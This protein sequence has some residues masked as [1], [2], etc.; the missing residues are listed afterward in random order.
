MSEKRKVPQQQKTRLH[1]RSRHRERYNF[2]TLIA[3]NPELEAYVKPNAYNDESIDYFNPDAV[4]A[5]NKALLKHHYGIDFWDIPEGYLCPP[6]PGRAD[7]LH[8]MADLLGFSN[9]GLIPVGREIVVLDIGVG[10]NCVYPLL[11]HKDYGWSFIGSE[12]DEIAVESAKKIVEFNQLK[13]RIGIRL[14]SDK[15]KIFEG[16]LLRGELFDLSICNPPFHASAEDARRG[17]LRKL[18]NLKQKTVTKPS[19][20][21]GGTNNE[22]W[23][24]GGEARF[25]QDMIKESKTFGN[26]VFWFSSVVSREQNIPK[27][28][29]ILKSEGAV[30]FKSI[31]MGQ[32]NK[33]S[34]I[35]AWT[36]L[37]KNDQRTWRNTRWDKEQP[38]A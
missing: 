23:C 28:F 10:A 36:F 34:H 2:K 12:I 25:I 7:Y 29:A 31:Q 5:L 33:T 1:P 8:Y 26:Q 18:S 3:A 16:V 11:G 35:L 22:L 4:K 30:D 15:N 24:E 20:N 27:L 21:F 13:T 38:G 17:N 9:H 32:G 6:I 19:L 37:S 14:Q